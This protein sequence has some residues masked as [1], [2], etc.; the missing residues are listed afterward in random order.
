MAGL[1]QNHG[2]NRDGVSLDSINVNGQL[3]KFQVDR[4]NATIVGAK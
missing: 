2:Q 3:I 1:N 4:T